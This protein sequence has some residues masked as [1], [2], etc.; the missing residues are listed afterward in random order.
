MNIRECY[1]EMG[2]DFGDVLARMMKE[3]RVKKF[4][5]RFLDDPSFGLLKTSLEAKNY[6]EAFRAAHTIKGV[7][8]NLSFTALYKSSHDLCEALRGG[9]ALEDVS[10]YDKV[11]RDYEMTVA[12]LKKVDE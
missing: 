7:S 10:L 12:A 5:L 6:D 9:K 4:A 11:V 3:E 2:A 8:Q 1:A